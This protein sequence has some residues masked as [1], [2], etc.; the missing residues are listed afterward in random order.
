MHSVRILVHKM[1]LISQPTISVS[2]IPSI[3]WQTEP[4][5]HG[6]CLQ[7]CTPDSHSPST[8]T[9]SSVRRAWRPPAAPASPNKCDSVGLTFAPCRGHHG[10]DVVYVIECPLGNG[11]LEDFWK[12]P[13]GGVHRDS[14]TVDAFRPQV[15]DTSRIVH[16]H[17]DLGPSAPS[18]FS[19]V[20]LYSAPDRCSTRR[21]CECTLA[22]VLIKSERQAR[23]KEGLH[24]EFYA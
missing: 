14:G 22:A 12:N 21:A 16:T 20:P 11:F 4:Y 9:T 18:P 24:L 19:L 3:R 1:H 8:N 5:R 2:S 15:H 13:Y 10:P 7:T 6:H 17:Q 23:W